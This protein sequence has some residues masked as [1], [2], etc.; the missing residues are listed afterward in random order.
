[1][2]SAPMEFGSVIL[3]AYW[4]VLLAELA[5]DKSI[6]TVA[7]LSFRFRGDLI[8]WGMLSAFGGKMLAAVLFGQFLVQAPLRL[9]AS[10]S[11]LTFFLAAIF[12]WRREVPFRSQGDAIAAGSPGKAAVPFASLFFTEWADLGQ[13]SAAGLA[14]RFHWALPVWIG[15]TLALLTKGALALTL[16]RKLRDR[17]PFV[18]LRV[19]GAVSCCV[20]GL[21]ALG[22]WLLPYL[23]A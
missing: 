19:C 5:G 14:G 15:G 16:G 3:I 10:V 13:I 17:I 12:I 9:T 20:L 22:E 11:A 2:Y 21:L 8:W 23:R 18:P 4:T 6:Y 1:M 7:S